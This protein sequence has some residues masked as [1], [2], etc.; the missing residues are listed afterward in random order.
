M[1][2]QRPVL[3]ARTFRLPRCLT[4]FEAFRH[5]PFSTTTSSP[6]DD[7]PNAAPPLDPSESLRQP[8]RML[9]VSRSYFTGTPKFT[10][11]ELKLEYLR[12]KYMDLPSYG[13]REAPRVAW[14]VRGQFLA[15]VNEEISVSRY[16]RLLKSLKVLN[17]IKAE[18]MP[19][20][21][22]QFIEEFSR[23]R[24]L[25]QWEL[26][27]RKPDEDGRSRGIGR[28]KTAHATA[29]LVEGDGQIIINGK[30]ISEVFPRLHDRESAMWALKATNR[31]HKYNVFAVARGGGVTGQAE[32]VTL[33]V[34][35]SLLVHEPGL[36]SALRRAGVIRTDPRQ[37]ERKKPGKLKSRK[38]PAW[39][40]R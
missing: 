12:A 37:V 31:L 17:K 15:K 6:L 25:Y 11:Y 27:P 39:V 21:V 29:Y 22:S 19:A 3:A 2:W 5:Q 9:P 30:T 24:N 40:K 34:A 16:A 38:M 20:E 4:Q 14:L 36:K 35:K 8:T 26:N 33:A 1:A 10:D 18:V 13:P 7:S 32:A 28:R 23:P